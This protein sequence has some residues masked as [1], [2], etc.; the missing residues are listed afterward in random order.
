MDEAIAAAATMDTMSAKIRKVPKEEIELKY[1]KMVEKVSNIQVT[2]KKEDVLDIIEK[3]QADFEDDNK[4]ILLSENEH[5]SMLHTNKSDQ[6]YMPRDNDDDDDDTYDY[7][8]ITI[9]W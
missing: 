5:T 8:H 7:W 2:M 4:E 1:N 3:W 6:Q 9:N